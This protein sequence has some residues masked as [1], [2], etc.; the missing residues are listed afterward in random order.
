MTQDLS[1]LATAWEMHGPAPLMHRVLELPAHLLSERHCAPTR[2]SCG[3][4]SIALRSLEQEDAAPLA[5]ALHLLHAAAA[6]A[7]VYCAL[8]PTQQCAMGAHVCELC[9]GADRRVVVHLHL[10][11][12]AQIAAAAATVRNLRS[13]L[14]EWETSQGSAPF[15]ALRDAIFEVTDPQQ[16]SCAHVDV[17]ISL[18]QTLPST[19]D[20]D[21][22]GRLYLEETK[23]LCAKAKDADPAHWLRVSLVWYS[24]SMDNASPL[25]A[26]IVST[27][28]SSEV[29]MIFS[30]S[31]WWRQ[32]VLEAPSSLR[33]RRLVFL[34]DGDD[35]ETFNRLL[36]LV[37]QHPE[38]RELE[39]IGAL[40]TAD[41]SLRRS[42][43]QATA[44]TLLVGESNALSLEKLRLELGP[45]TDTDAAVLETALAI[46]S[47]ESPASPRNVC[48][49]HVICCLGDLS[50]ACVVSL[51]KLLARNGVERVE[52]GDLF[53]R[54]VPLYNLE[55]LLENCPTLRVLKCLCVLAT[56]PSPAQVTRSQSSLVSLELDVGARDA[57]ECS[58]SMR[59]FLQRWGAS[60]ET[61]SLSAASTMFDGAVASAIAAHCPKVKT[62]QVRK[63]T[64]DFVDTIAS[65]QLDSVIDLQVPSSFGD[66]TTMYNA[67][68]EA[69]RTNS[70]AL[71]RLLVS[72]VGHDEAATRSVCERL[73]AALD[74]T[75]SLRFVE[76]H[77][78]SSDTS[79]NSSQHQRHL[80]YLDIE[81]EGDFVELFDSLVK[82]TTIQWP[83]RRRRLAFLS[84][85]AKHRLPRDASRTVL[86]FAGRKAPRVVVR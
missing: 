13:A 37:R 44:N 78:A 56:D 85:V 50:P 61:L 4:V 9:D 51:A 62:L 25:N 55:L 38:L 64:R 84:A 6:D 67:L 1:A 53:D 41:A 32:H 34:F 14:F 31:E 73:R 52:A 77:A 47:S 7:R 59:Q 15:H 58:S 22:G 11:L 82:R 19:A 26:Q 63:F 29:P 10:A 5:E 74:G 86:E 71:N 66:D 75:T 28:A 16:R 83:A 24:P 27:W 72:I 65:S 18:F 12:S 17:V 48:Y 60:L 30:V 76:L 35:V 36:Q 23:K 21:D 80:P 43:L 39:I 33:L 70:M 8:W 79:R 42:A 69:L 20:D 46:S 68:F 57:A 40:S 54:A 49:R 81:P 3:D 2:V 45:L